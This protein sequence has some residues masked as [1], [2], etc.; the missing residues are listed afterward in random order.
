MSQGDIEN[1]FREKKTEKKKRKERQFT[2]EEIERH[3]KMVGAG[4]RILRNKGVSVDHPEFQTY[5]KEAI[6]ILFGIWKITSPEEQS[7]IWGILA[8]RLEDGMQETPEEYFQKKRAKE[9]KRSFEEP[10]KEE[11]REQLGKAREELRLLIGRKKATAEAIRDAV[12]KVIT[13][14]MFPNW[15]TREAKAKVLKYYLCAENGIPTS[16]PALKNL[17]DP[18]RQKDLF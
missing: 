2:D 13:K 7:R 16:D 6:N 10:V 4:L 11:I 14:Q 5:K 8:A 17:A 3:N 15:K 9:L 12:Y 1:P 18:E